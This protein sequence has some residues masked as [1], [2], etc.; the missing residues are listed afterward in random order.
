P[1]VVAVRDANNNPV[2]NVTITFAVTAGGGTVT[3]ATMA[4][5]AQGQA[6]STLTLGRTAGANTVTATTTGLPAVTFTATGTPG[7]ATVLAIASGNNQTAVAGATLPNPL[8]V[9]VRDANNNPVSN[10]T[11]TF[12]VTAGGGTITPATMATNAQGQASTSLKLG[13]TA[14]ANTVTASAT[15][16]TT[17]SFSAS[18]TAAPATQLVIASGNNQTGAAGSTLANPLVVTA[19]D[20]A[21]NPVANV[22]ITFAVTAGGGT[23]TPATMATNA[24]GQASTSLRLGATPATNTVT[25]TATGLPVATFTATGTPPPPSSIAIVSGNGQKARIGMVCAAPLVVV[26]RD[27]SGA[28]LS[29]VNV[30]FAVAVGGGSISPSSMATNAQGQAQTTLTVGKTLGSNTVTAT[31]TGLTPATFTATAEPLTYVDDVRPIMMARC[32]VCHGPGGVQMAKPWTSYNE[33][34]FAV[35]FGGL[36][37][38]TPFQPA[39]SFMIQ[40]TQ[41]GGSMSGFLPAAEAQVLLD[42]VNTGA[43]E[44]NLGTLPASRLNV[45]SGNNQSAPAGSILPNPLVLTAVDVNGKGVAGVAISWTVTAGGGALSSVIAT[46]DVNGVASARLTLGAAGGNNTVSASAPG[47]TAVGFTATGVLGYS[48]APL[49]G[50]TNPLDVAALVALRANNVEPVT[51]ASDGEFL[52]RATIVLLGRLPSASELDAFVANAN[53]NKRATTIDTLLASSEFATHWAVDMFGPWTETSPTVT[54]DV[55][56]VQTTY[57]YDAPITTHIL[58]DTPLST[59]VKNL[60]TGANQEGMAFLAAH[61]GNGGNSMAD[62]LMLTF[63][64]MTSKCARCH[65]HPLSSTA[66]DPRWIQD[67]N[68]GLY[69]FFAL[70]NGDATKLD[71]SGRR[72][73]TAVQPRWV[74]DGYASA[75]TGL[76]LLSDPVATRRARFGDLLVASN[77][78]ARGTAHRIW[79]EVATPL[80]D[81]NQFL[82]ANLD[83]VRSPALLTALRDEFKRQNTSLKGFLRSCLNS[84]LFQLSSSS[85]TAAADPYQGRYQLRRLH[86][87]TVQSGVASLTGVAF[88]QNDVFR[89]SFG[90][91][92]DRQLITERKDDPTTDQALLQ[93]NSTI[94]TPG[95]VTNASS[96]IASLAAAVDGGAVKS[97]IP[98]TVVT[99][100]GGTQ[101][102]DVTYYDNMDFTGTTVVRVDPEINFDFG[103]G[104]PDGRIGVDTF[105]ARWTATL[106]IATAG[107]YTFYPT[108]DDGVR[109][110]V[111]GNLVIDKFIDQGPTEYPAT[112]NLTAGNHTI[113]MD[114]YENGGGASAQLRWSS[115]ALGGAMTYTQA[116]TTLVRAALQRDP[117]A[118]E[119]TAIQNARTASTTTRQA[120]EDL[121]VALTATTEFMHR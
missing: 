42:W 57:Q 10:V 48:G 46:T 17:V 76:P 20:A 4:T 96:Q 14:G 38:I 119:M 41:A 26:V 34:R 89:F 37:I 91:P 94:S 67:D 82:K 30:T 25:A 117:T 15:G 28:A 43:L 59:V 11:I 113:R 104:S 77:A 18:G 75:P 95:K 32:I 16:L 29:G 51:L 1:L 105:S 81:E 3:P 8:V 19:R 93:M 103:N 2:S 63:T 70:S 98:R 88:G 112:V 97:I 33:I 55:N 80:L 23:V 111:D 56:G 6:S 65:D 99:T 36:P 22:T 92:V 78:F 115:P 108:T 66:D 35:S 83:A 87:E 12:A 86:S 50:S 61:G 13:G 73:G 106:K 27:A 72:F 109:L 114:Y 54:M 84:R 47:L 85:T 24:Q 71:R 52:R 58:N 31:V 90:Y 69:A 107:A 68:Y 5:N 79:A 40:K 100:A 120:L 7:P 116:A 101:G 74:A 21:G 53:A 118:A 39:N 64:G 60:A 110:Y 102:F 45:T 44:D 49:T 9:A 121:A 62:Q